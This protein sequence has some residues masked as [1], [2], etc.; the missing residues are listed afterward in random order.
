M[1][2]Y[3]KILNNNTTEKTE[4]QIVLELNNYLKL[5]NEDK[6]FEDDPWNWD[7]LVFTE[8]AKKIKENKEDKEILLYDDN[9]EI[10]YLLTKEKADL[11]DLLSFKDLNDPLEIRARELRALAEKAVREAKWASDLAKMARQNEYLKIHLYKNNKEFHDKKL[12]VL[13]NMRKGEEFLFLDKIMVQQILKEIKNKAPHS[14]FVNTG[15]YA[16]RK[17]KDYYYIYTK[18]LSTKKLFRIINNFIPAII[19]K[20]EK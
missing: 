18:D 15:T 2:N 16:M 10:K 13:N 11:N 1:A 19:I 7:Y 5:K 4:E 12:Q 8:E 20:G 9:G 3:I 14:I 17:D 6:I